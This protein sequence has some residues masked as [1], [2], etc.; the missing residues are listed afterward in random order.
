MIRYAKTTLYKCAVTVNATR[1]EPHEAA[2]SL[3]VRLVNFED[4]GFS[5]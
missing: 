1:E 5:N 2:A 3:L 4:V